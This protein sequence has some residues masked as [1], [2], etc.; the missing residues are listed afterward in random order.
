[1]VCDDEGGLMKSLMELIV[2]AKLRLGKTI[3][4]KKTETSTNAAMEFQAKTRIVAKQSTEMPHRHSDKH[5]ITDEYAEK[6]E[7]YYF[8]NPT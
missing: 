7:S 3:E 6:A 5:Y 4:D 2:H 8:P 1:M